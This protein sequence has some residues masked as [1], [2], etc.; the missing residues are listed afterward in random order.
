MATLGFLK[1][2]CHSCGSLVL[3]TAMQSA[4]I[5]CAFCKTVLNVTQND[6]EEAAAAHKDIQAEIGR[7]AIRL[8]QITMTM[9]DGNS[10]ETQAQ[11]ITMLQKETHDMY[12]RIAEYL[13]S[14]ERQDERGQRHECKCKSNS[15]S[16]SC[17]CEVP[18]L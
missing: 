16:S 2:T 9:N 4:E 14:I 11:A 8:F 17:D 18:S 7:R 15:D 6:A 1:L 3:A 10:Q 12:E 13:D 5:K